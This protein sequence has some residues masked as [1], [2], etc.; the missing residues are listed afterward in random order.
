MG[1]KKIITVLAGG[2]GAAKFLQG[3][4]QVIPKSEITVIVNTG[5]DIEKYELHI[6]PDLD[7][8]MYTLSGIVDEKKGWG[9][10]DDSFHCLDMLQKYGFNTW[11]NLGDRDLA[12]HL[13]RTQLLRRGFTL[14][15]T[16]D[17]LRRQLKVKSRII[18]MTNYKFQTKIKTPKGT[19]DFQ[20]YLVKGKAQ[21]K[22]LSVCFDGEEKAKPSPGIVESLMNSKGIIISPSNPVVSIGTILAVKGIK[23]ALKQTKT[24]IA[25]ISPIV[26][27]ATI[28]GPADILMSSLGLEVSSWG[29]AKLYEEFLDLMI[30]DQIDRLEKE[31]IEKL[32]IDV[33]VTNTIMQSLKEKIQLARI[34][35]KHLL[36]GNA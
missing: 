32:G 16:T 18:P 31:R 11:F 5:D 22:V 21:D 27:G 13:Y 7:I 35:V 12:T 1:E 34:V 10:R 6:S 19:I 25:A 29:V 23:K 26:G 17:K 9:L 24:K 33:V 20:E 3:L 4:V 14:S 15:E 8:I 2:V 30:I 28:K 36:K